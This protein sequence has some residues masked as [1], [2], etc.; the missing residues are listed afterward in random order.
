MSSAYYSSYIIELVIFPQKIQTPLYVNLTGEL[1]I[2]NPLSTLYIVF[3][4]IFSL[5]KLT[6]TLLR[7]KMCKMSSNSKSLLLTKHPNIAHWLKV[8]A[9]ETKSRQV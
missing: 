2:G 9:L 7:W 5:L 4:S 6:K 8:E 1:H 3:N